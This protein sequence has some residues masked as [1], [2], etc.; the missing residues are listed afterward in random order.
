M[1]VRHCPSCRTDYRPEIDVCYD[2]GE[3]LVDRDDEEPEPQTE[4]DKADEGD[5]I[6]EGFVP[7][8]GA[9]LARD[10][11]PLADALIAAGIDCRIRDVRHGSHV[12]G[13]RILVHEDQRGTATEIIQQEAAPEEGAQ[14]LGAG[15]EPGRGYLRCPACQTELPNGAPECPECGLPLA[16][17]QATCP[18][19][20]TGLD[21]EAESC[22]HCGADLTP[23]E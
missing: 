15:F 19:C 21:A 14:D 17:M 1:H 3:P 10:L 13:Y 9:S 5:V 11:T 4:H 16:T 20:G 8:F 2:C 6:P 18:A 22:S 7:V 23:S 12:T